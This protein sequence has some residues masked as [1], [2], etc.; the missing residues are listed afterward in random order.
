METS[1]RALTARVGRDVWV[2][3]GIMVAVGLLGGL[4]TD[5]G[6]WYAALRQ[7]DWKPPDWLFGPMWTLIYGTTAWAGVRTWR[8][9]HGGP[10]RG[11]FLVACGL[12]GMLNVLWSL[13]YFTLRRPDWALAE[14]VVLWLSAAW[15][16]ALMA[17]VDRFSV[18]LMMPHLSWLTVA[19]LLNR[20]TLT[21]N[22]GPWGV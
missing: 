13:L 19:L 2:A 20:A 4:A 17:R 16:T 5:I 18:G 12:N 6:P 3:T 14:G 10:S 11:W 9:L 22:A 21:L 7:P 8:R 15:V 1:G